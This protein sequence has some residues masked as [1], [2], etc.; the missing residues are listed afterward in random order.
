MVAIPYSLILPDSALQEQLNEKLRLNQRPFIFVAIGITTTILF[1][2]IIHVLFTEKT[3]DDGFLTCIFILGFFI[4]VLSLP[5]YSTKIIL[6]FRSFAC[7]LIVYA[8]VKLFEG[9]DVCSDSVDFFK[10]FFIKRQ[11]TVDNYV[12]MSIYLTPF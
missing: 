2:G 6:I 9:I 12:I 10:V 8:H 1:T 4:L 5:K 11:S 7:I 3:F